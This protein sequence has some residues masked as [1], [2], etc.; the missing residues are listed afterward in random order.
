[1]KKAVVGSR[2]V[3]LF[4]FIMFVGSTVS[5]TQGAEEKQELL[6][7]ENHSLLRVAPLAGDDLQEFLR[8]NFD[9]ARRLPDGGFE[10]VATASDRE[11]LIGSFGARVDVENME[12][13]YR[14]GLSGTQDM[15]GYHTYS[16]TYTKLSF[17][18]MVFSDLVDLDTIGYSLEGNA[19]WAVKISDNVEVDED[20]PEVMFNSLIHAR[21]AI[22]LEINLAF[23][24]ELLNNYHSDPEIADLVDNTEIYLVPIINVDGYLYNEATNPFGGGMWRKN[25]RDNGDGTFGVDLNRNWG[26]NWG[27]DNFSS[28]PNGISEIYRGAGPFSEPATQVMRDW[29]N[30]R[31]FTLVM[32]YHAYGGMYIGP[33]AFDGGIPLPDN[34][35]NRLILD[36]LFAANPYNINVIGFHN[37]SALDWQYGEQ[38]TKKKSYCI[39]PEVGTSFWPPESAIH[40]LVAA[41]VP[42]NFAIVRQA[43]L[44]W[45]RPSRS[46]G[47]EFAFHGDTVNACTPDYTDEVTFYNVDDSEQIQVEYSL[48][49]MNGPPGWV[50]LDADTV[51]VDP[52]NNFLVT[53]NL[54]PQATA[55]LAIGSEYIM[56]VWLQLVVSKTSDPAT[57][58]T[59]RYPVFQW[60]QMFDIDGD[61]LI[62]GCDN[63]PEIANAGQEDMDEDG[64]G[65]VC[66]DDIDGDG[67]PNESD[68]C[69]L[70]YNPPQLDS[71]LDGTGDACECICGVWGDV[72]DD[73]EINPVDVVYLVNFV[74]KN[75]DG[76][77]VWPDCPHVTGDVNCDDAVNPVD[78]VYYVNFVYKN[79]DAFCDDPCVQ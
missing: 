56:G 41:N 79:Q 37:G 42:A 27:W 26:Y 40:G 63:C 24:D 64:I 38:L 78:V 74:Y 9:I 48:N 33:W 8:H 66:D 36:S 23:M 12:E 35:I 4:L 13:T 45:Q 71:D 11:L 60:V 49:D 62:D 61:L 2:I 10:V 32:N 3:F 22:G 19:I 53:L 6:P 67:F 75:I 52:G 44:L 47:T 34:T 59:L 31:D 21:E 1:M 51:I 73:G 14:L 39:L 58:D 28:S 15:G 77:T 29:M 7:Y 50:M 17:M 5:V 54:S 69:P 76:R 30:T 55:G 46:L 68:N 72:N 20:E 16:E 25:R 65:D 43:H 18:A 57:V 70:V